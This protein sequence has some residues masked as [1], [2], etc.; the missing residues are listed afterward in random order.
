MA[1]T[2]PPH[3]QLVC[4]DLDGTLVD[5]T[6]YI[7]S[8]LHE[9][10]GSDPVR[11]R[12]AHDDHRAGRIS[13]EAW[14]RTDLELLAERGADR[15]G[16]IGALETLVPAEGA[17]ETLHTLKA[18]GY[19]LGL[20]SGSL[21]LVLE[22]FFPDAP[23]DHVFINQVHFDSQGRIAGGVPT[24]YDLAGKADGL[25]AIARSEGLT[26][27]GCAFVGDNVNDL[28]V[29]RTA[30]FS[31]GVNVKHPRVAQAADVVLDGSDLRDLLALFSGPGTPGGES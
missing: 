16:M 31:V 21:G 27:R 7:W 10:F 15:A 20:I 30:G 3:V 24:R 28:E 25:A 11:R 8:T 14:F 5:N 23:F 19:K 17:T 13:Y 18:R 1:L 22:H 2:A 4:F 26:A 12:R 6:V 9:H 29:M